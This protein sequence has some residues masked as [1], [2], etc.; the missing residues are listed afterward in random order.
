MIL[1]LN[2]LTTISSV[3]IEEKTRERLN[4]TIL[5]QN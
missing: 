4:S 2:Y 1:E 3:Y 5:E